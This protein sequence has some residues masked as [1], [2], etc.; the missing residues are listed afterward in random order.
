MPVSKD[1]YRKHM[2]AH[3]KFMNRLA[4]DEDEPDDDEPD[5]DDEDDEPDD[6]EPQGKGRRKAI[7]P[8]RKRSS[9]S[10]SGSGSGRRSSGSGS[11]Y[12]NPAWFGRGR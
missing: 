9:S 2:R 6:D 4:E 10:G 11:S 8:P 7:P 12:G 1:E 3:H 5:D